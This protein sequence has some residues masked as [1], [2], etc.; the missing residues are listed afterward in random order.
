MVYFDTMATV[1]EAAN[2]TFPADVGI[3]RLDL[4]DPQILDVVYGL[5]REA[6][7]NV[8]GVLPLHT[9]EKLKDFLCYKHP[10]SETYGAAAPGQAEL[11]GYA[12]IAPTNVYPDEARTWRVAEL[13]NIGVHPDRARARG[14][15]SFLFRYCLEMAAQ[16][17]AC[18]LDLYVSPDNE[19][20][21]AFYMNTC[22]MFP[23]V[24]MGDR[25]FGP[26]G[27]ARLIL[28]RRT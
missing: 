27:G 15:G 25:P 13:V 16:H 17:G 10:G 3:L 19:R 28:T 6:T 11:L 12:T 18:R 20:A 24:H 26:E 21:A 8:P 7:E 1:Y 14:I 2:R 4:D 9:P 22:G 5:D 23:A